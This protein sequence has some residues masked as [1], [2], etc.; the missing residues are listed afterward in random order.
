MMV[1]EKLSSQDSQHRVLAVYTLSV[2]AENAGEQIRGK[3]LKEFLKMFGKSLKDP[4]L[5]VC[6]YTITALTHLVKIHK[7]VERFINSWEP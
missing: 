1:Q 6:F 2:L 3:S 7:N 5:E 4:E